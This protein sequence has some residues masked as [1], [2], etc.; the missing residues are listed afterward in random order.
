MFVEALNWFQQFC[1]WLCSATSQS[2]GCS[3]LD[4]STTQPDQPFW[5]LC[6]LYNT[7]SPWG[8]SPM[9]CQRIQNE[10]TLL[11]SQGYH[12]RSSPQKKLGCNS[13]KSAHLDRLGLRL[14][15]QQPVQGALQGNQSW[16]TRW[17]NKIM[18]N[19][20]PVRIIQFLGKAPDI[21]YPMGL[22]PGKRASEWT[23]KPSST[24]RPSYLKISKSFLLSASLDLSITCVARLSTITIS[25]TLPP[26]IKRWMRVLQD[27]MM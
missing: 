9:W 15:P 17:Q 23:E 21:E 16:A 6:K 12:T 24:S 3:P 19:L 7:I 27:V 4:E 14:L 5:E 26:P 25:P 22:R 8:E 11:H 2:A 10:T 18:T 20:S 13:S 1:I